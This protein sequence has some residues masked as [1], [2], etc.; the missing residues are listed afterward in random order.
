MANSEIDPEALN[1]L[2]EN[3]W[4]EDNYRNGFVNR[5][6]RDDISYEDLR[7]HDLVVTRIPVEEARRQRGLAWLRSRIAKPP[8]A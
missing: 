8:L 2:D 7:D 5:R 4:T 6:E 1:L 3:N